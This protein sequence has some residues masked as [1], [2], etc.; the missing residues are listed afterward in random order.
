MKFLREAQNQ[1][2]VRVLNL[3]DGLLFS[4]SFGKTQAIQIIRFNVT[5]GDDQIH[6]VS[7]FGR[8]RLSIEIQ[9]SSEPVE[10]RGN[11]NRSGDITI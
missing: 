3:L 8:P 1:A 6:H 7:L 10:S 11:L 5:C 4:F 9:R 2:H